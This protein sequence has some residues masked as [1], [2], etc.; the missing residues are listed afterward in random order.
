LSG[1]FWFYF[2]L[3]FRATNPRIRRLAERMAAK[4]AAN[5]KHRFSLPQLKRLS[6]T[7]V[8]FH[9]DPT[10]ADRLRELSYIDLSYVVTDYF[11]RRCAGDRN[12][13]TRIAVQ[14][15]C[16]TLGMRNL[17]R[18]T[19]HEQTAL[20]RLAPLVVNI[21]DLAL[22]PTRDKE[23]L[24]RVIRAK[25][26]PREREYVLRLQRHVRLRGALERLEKRKRPA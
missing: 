12:E 15:L 5:P 2:K 17:K 6:H 20:A 19:S 26:G 13:G 7:D 21:P 3:G 9:A 16:R 1:A 4:L 11:A 24:V 25:G 18:W 14:A 23:D 22:W 10:E 8:Y